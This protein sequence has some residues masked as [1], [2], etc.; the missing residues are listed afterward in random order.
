M[1]KMNLILIKHSTS[2]ENLS[3]YRDR[4]MFQCFIGYSKLYLY[5]SMYIRRRG[6]DMSKLS[7]CI[8][9]DAAMFEKQ[10]F[11]CIILYITCLEFVVSS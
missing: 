5:T 1:I 9:F 2:S 8:A 3:I 7:C 6:L 11:Y 4:V 10:L